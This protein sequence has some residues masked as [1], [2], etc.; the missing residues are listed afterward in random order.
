[1]LFK[2]QEAKRKM[3]EWSLFHWRFNFFHLFIIC[4]EC[5]SGKS[6]GG[7]LFL[8]LGFLVMTHVRDSERDRKRCACAS[9]CICACKTINN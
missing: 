2:N 8:L 3:S 1:M 6:E 9:A 5:S 4:L 7:P